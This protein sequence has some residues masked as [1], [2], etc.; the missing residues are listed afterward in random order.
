MQYLMKRHFCLIF[1][2]HT[3]CITLVTMQKNICK[4]SKTLFPSRDIDDERIEKTPKNKKILQS[5]WTRAQF[6]L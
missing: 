5:N 2:W 4:E 6:G 1:P 3:Y